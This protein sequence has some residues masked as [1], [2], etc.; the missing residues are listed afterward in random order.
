LFIVAVGLLAGPVSIAAAQYPAAQY[1]TTQ[2]PATQYPAIPADVYATEIPSRTDLFAPLDAFAGP[3][4]GFEFLPSGTLYP[5][6][7]AGPKE[8][9]LSTQI[10]RETDDGLLWDATLGGRFGW[11]RGTSFDGARAWQVDVEAAAILR[12]DPDQEV[13]LRSVDYRAGI[14]LTF[15]AGA[16]RFKLGYYH[17]SAHAGDEFLLKNPGFQRLNYVR[18]AIV[19]GYARYFGER[20]RV[21]GETSWAF[22]SEISDPWNF[23]FGYEIAPT[24][25]TGIVGEPFFAING[26]LRQEVD[27]SG[28]TT[29]H[30]GWAWRDAQAAR[31]LRAGLFLQTG[32]S[33]QYEFHDTSET[34]VGAGLWYDF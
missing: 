9:R 8:S 5:A 6:Y 31:L 10:F 12:L 21:Y 27:F 15:A 4:S 22:F 7:L 30:A 18:D 29:V 33:S 14:P 20:V 1:P 19:L 17:L 11:F 23:Q 24:R 34:L 28:T 2:Y 13:D 26:L 25:P 32:K 16:N 3:S